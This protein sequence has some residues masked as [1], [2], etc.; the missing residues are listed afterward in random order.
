M[1]FILEKGS[2]VELCV[3]H[4]KFILKILLLLT[5]LNHILRLLVI[6]S[7]TTGSFDGF[8]MRICMNTFNYEQGSQFDLAYFIL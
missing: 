8:S 6:I 1:S 5:W 4:T 2:R 7:A 3:W